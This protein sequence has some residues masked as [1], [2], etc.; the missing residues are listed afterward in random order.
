MTLKPILDQVDIEKLYQHL[1]YIEGVKH[2]LDN[3]EFLDE[4]ANYLRWTMDDFGLET[5][6]HTF[7]VN[8]F[9]FPFR[10]I[11]G[12]IDNGSN[13]EILVTSHYDTMNVSPGVNDNGSGVAGMLEIARLLVNTKLKYNI[14]FIGFTLEECHPTRE[15]IFRQLMINSEL[16]DEELRFTS[17]HT[18]KLLDKIDDL[19]EEAIIQGKSITEAWQFAY[20]SVKNEATKKEL[21]YVEALMKHYANITR[22]NWIGKTICVGSTAWVKE[23]R[24][25]LDKIA[26]VLN[27]EEIGY[28]TENKY[29]QKY[30]YGIDPKNHPSYKIDLDEMKGNFVGIFADKNSINLAHTF[31]Q[32]CQLESIDLPFHNLEV[33]M[34]FEEISLKLIDLL[35]SD[36]APFWREKIPAITITDTFEFRYPYYHTEADIMDN[37]NFDFM[38]KICQATIASLINMP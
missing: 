20:N 3:P 5:K 35:R 14:R 36:H 10:N 11:E 25:S 23:H 18:I 17:Y 34:D 26:G 31:C 9:D 8:G 27:L 12:L 33:A 37:L 22:N 21:Q 15:R 1:L 29:S 38:K 30:P 4:V 13:S 28:T 16:V 7:R 19:R 2:P 24:K 32:Q 6:E